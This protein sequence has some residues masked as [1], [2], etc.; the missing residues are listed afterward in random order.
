[1]IAYR[2]VFAETVLGINRS[3]SSPKA[4]DNFSLP[5]EW[6]VR[7]TISNDSQRS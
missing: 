4:L 1:M 2:C 7:V 5:S 6:L 3:A